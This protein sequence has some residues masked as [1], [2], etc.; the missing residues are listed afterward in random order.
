MVLVKG[1]EGFNCVSFVMGL[2][3]V[4]VIIG[5]KCLW[6]GVRFWMVV[7]LIFKVEIYCF[8]C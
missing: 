2:I 4:D 6:W 8:L 3:Y 5:G 7:I 1:F